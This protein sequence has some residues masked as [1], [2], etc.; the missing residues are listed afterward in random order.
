MS[1]EYEAALREEKD[2]AVKDVE[3]HAAEEDSDQN[4]EFGVHISTKAKKAPEEKSPGLIR[5]CLRIC[6]SVSR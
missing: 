4:V 5:W 3:R 1:R 2:G 6:R